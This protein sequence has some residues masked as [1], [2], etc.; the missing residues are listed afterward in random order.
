MSHVPGTVPRTWLGGPGFV[1]Q[2]GIA[3]VERIGLNRPNRPGQRD[4]PWDGA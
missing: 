2:S 4:S 3:A 1:E